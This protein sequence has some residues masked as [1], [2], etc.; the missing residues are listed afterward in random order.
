MRRLRNRGQGDDD[1]IHRQRGRKSRNVEEV[2][3]TNNSTQ[4]R[5]RQKEKTSQV[6]RLTAKTRKAPGYASSKLKKI[7]PMAPEKEYKL[8]SNTSQQHGVKAVVQ[9]K[10]H[11]LNTLREA[12]DENRDLPVALQ[13]ELNALIHESPKRKQPVKSKAKPTAKPT[14]N[15]LIHAL[16]EETFFLC[17]DCGETLFQED[18]DE[19]SEFLVQVDREMTE[20][21]NINRIPTF[22]KKENFQEK[23]KKVLEFTKALEEDAQMQ[24]KETKVKV[25]HGE[26]DRLNK[27]L[28]RALW[29]FLNNERRKEVFTSDHIRSLLRLHFDEV[30]FAKKST[31]KR[32]V[33]LAELE[34]IH[35]ENPDLMQ[36]A[37]RLYL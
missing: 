20:P 8:A 6:T 9:E 35:D 26:V 28:P 34:K 36:V 32:D 24:K 16:I 25:K 31:C 1:D 30:T 11:D 17:G 13:I 27:L 4:Q 22:D 5:G 10:R 2:V 23:T 19:A 21:V 12:P 15:K 14:L 18:L 29:M 33:L 3:M 7:S 37:A